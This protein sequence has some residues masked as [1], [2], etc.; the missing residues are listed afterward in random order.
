MRP[1]SSAAVNKARLEAVAQK[2]TDR[3]TDVGRRFSEPA[4]Q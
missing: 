3:P 1:R 4:A 2:G